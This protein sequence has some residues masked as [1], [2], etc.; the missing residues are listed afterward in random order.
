MGPIDK[1]ISTGS[2]DGSAR[3]RCQA[4]SW[5]RL[6][7]TYECLNLQALSLKFS[8]LYKSRIFPIM[9]KKVCAS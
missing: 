4:I 1:K 7:Y 3:N 8:S 9:D 2:G 6:K 5:G